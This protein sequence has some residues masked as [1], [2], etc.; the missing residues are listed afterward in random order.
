[1]FRTT[2]VLLLI[3]FILTKEAGARTVLKFTNAKCES[4]NKSWAVINECRLRAFKRNL[5]GL[6]IN[7]TLLHPAHDIK[8]AIVF[9]KRA[10][11]YK[12]FVLNTTLNACEY[13]LKK[14][15]PVANLVYPLFRDFSNINHTCPYVGDQILKNFYTRTE[16]FRVI[17]PNG[18]YVVLLSW[19]LRNIKTFTTDVYFTV[20]TT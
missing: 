20:M 5:V 16:L 3:C 2:T 19:I 1:M 17:F 7:I 9:L 8:L 15:N 4:F 14:N 10:N 11:G 6:N 18:D 13:I 12:P